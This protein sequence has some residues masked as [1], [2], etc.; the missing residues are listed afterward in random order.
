MIED[1][2]KGLP[3]PSAAARFYQ[4]FKGR[5][6]A[7]TARLERKKGLLSD[8][9]T[10]AAF[11]PLLATTIIQ[12]PEHLWWLERR[13]FDSGIR[14]KD[15]LL[16]SLARFSLTNSTLD[17]QMLFTRFRRREL[18]RIY[19]RDIRRLATV[20]EITEE[21]SN[22]ADAI[23][24]NALRAARQEMDNRFGAPQQTAQD[25]RTAAADV[26]IVSLGKLGSKE[27]NY[28]SDIDLL[29]IY[30]AEGTT[31]GGTRGSVS[32]REYFAKLAEYATKLVGQSVGEGAAY[33]V[34]LRLRPH[35]RIGSLALSLADT[36]KYYNG[37]AAQWERQVLIRSRASAGSAELFAE[38]FSAVESSVFAAGCSVEGSLRNVRLSKEKI[39]RE[40]GSGSSYNVKL[41]RGGIREIEFIAQALQLAYGGRDRWLRAPHTLISLSRLADRGWIRR[42]EMTELSSAYDLL[43]RLEHVLQ[44][45]HGL[46]THTLPVNEEKLALV[47]RRMNFAEPSAFASE[48]ERHTSNVRRIFDRVFTDR[49]AIDPPERSAPSELLTISAPAAATEIGSSDIPIAEKI[50]EFSTRFAA[51]LDADPEAAELLPDTSA[52]PQE[53]SHRPLLSPS[54]DADL[55]EQMAALRKKWSRLM[56][57]IAAFDIPGRLSLRDSKKMQTRLAEDSIA[58]ALAIAQ[59]E[60][61]RRFPEAAPVAVG[62]LALGKLGS[63]GMD[64]GSDLDLVIIYDDLHAAPG[65]MTNAEYSGRLADIFVASLSNMT[66][67]G[68]LYRVDRRLRPHGSSGPGVIG[69]SSFTCYMTNDAAIWELL[70]Y[71]KIRAV[72]GDM[73]LAERSE[74]DIRT[75]IHEKAGT[76]SADELRAETLRLRQRLEQEKAGN[77]RRREIDIKFGAGGMLD[78]YFAIR[79]LQLRDNI[80][81]VDGD[82]SSTFALEML[83]DAGSLSRQTAEAMIDGYAFLMAFDHCLRLMLT[84]STRVP[85]ANKKVLSATALRLGFDSVEALFRSLNLHRLAIRTGFDEV[86]RPPAAA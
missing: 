57:E 71:V 85:L 68:S 31:G 18:L 60:M 28:S 1:L 75:I 21:L 17:P 66:R 43:R 23:L 10:L 48:L 29:F 15:E 44:M 62:V 59:L 22:L 45:E 76:F 30:S 70:A 81:D 41:G 34:D 25:G 64:Y 69:A 72:G 14:S 73:D 3:D 55:P 49:P 39:D 67:E 63:G 24:E 65:K 82:R 58:A 84:R 19:L 37:E 56:L 74:K 11:S 79:F 2:I 12:D 42:R 47:A 33:R 26:V 32:N 16:E 53:L 83:A 86:L 61:S 6:A 51:M 9:L 27:L 77:L 40:H 13:R 54:P 52:Q 8:A 7:L 5:H 80:P 20:A 36:A 50:R 78:V 35:G 38:F 46:Q 4:E